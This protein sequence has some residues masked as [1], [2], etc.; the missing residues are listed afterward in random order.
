MYYITA[1]AHM[2]GPTNIEPKI[3]YGYQPPS[4]LH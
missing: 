2:H 4:P 3:K 1:V